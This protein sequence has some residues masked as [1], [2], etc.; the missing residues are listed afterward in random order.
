[1]PMPSP[2]E[3]DYRSIMRKPTYKISIDTDR[4][5]INLFILDPQNYDAYI[6]GE[7]FKY[8]GEENMINGYYN[9]LVPYA[10]GPFHVILEN[11]SDHPVKVHC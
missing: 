3:G 10:D 9:F 1:M 6:Y 7:P 11:P 4:D 2:Q 8:Q 5:P